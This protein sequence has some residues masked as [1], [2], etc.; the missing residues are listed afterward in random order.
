[1][2][3]WD[4]SWPSFFCTKRNSMKIYEDVKNIKGIGEKTGALLNKLGVYSVEDLLHFFPRTYIQ[5]SNPV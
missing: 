1:M 3:F 5:Y 2:M 4:G